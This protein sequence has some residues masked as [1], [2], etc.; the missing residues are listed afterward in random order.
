MAEAG[1]PVSDIWNSCVNG[2]IFE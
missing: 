2:L 1:S